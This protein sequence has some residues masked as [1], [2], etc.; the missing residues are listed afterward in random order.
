MDKKHIALG[1]GLGVSLLLNSYAIFQLSAQKHEQ[2]EFAIW[3]ANRVEETGNR[4]D[5][6]E[7]KLKDLEPTHP[8]ESPMS[9]LL[10]EQTL[11][12]RLASVERESESATSDVRDLQAKFNNLCIET[13]GRVCL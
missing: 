8:Q 7:S 9:R 5:D 2:G 6:L 13:N 1:A 3:T 12:N 4:I 11:E 10:A